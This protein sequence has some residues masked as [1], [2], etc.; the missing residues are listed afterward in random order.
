VTERLFRVAKLYQRSA[1]ALEWAARHARVTGEP[2]AEGEVPRGAAHALAAEGRAAA[3]R[4]AFDEASTL[5][6]VAS[7][8]TR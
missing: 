2:F 1:E 5:H 6:A 8:V 4:R 7:R 3:A